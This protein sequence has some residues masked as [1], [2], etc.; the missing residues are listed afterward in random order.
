MANDS[1]SSSRFIN[2]RGQ[3]YIN[4]NIYYVEKAN[5]MISVYREYEI[6][7]KLYYVHKTLESIAAVHD[8]LL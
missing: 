6:D 3:R 1:D 7:N 4:D 2:S 5:Y 8:E